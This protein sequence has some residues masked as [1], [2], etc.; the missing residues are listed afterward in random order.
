M[1]TQVSFDMVAM[2]V[3]YVATHISE[4]M[5]VFSYIGL[6][7]TTQVSFDIFVARG[8]N[9]RVRYD[10]GGLRLVGSLKTWVS[11]DKEPYKRDYVLQKRH[12]LLRSL[13]IIATS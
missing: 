6:F 12:V 3:R 2:R 10:M 8:S 11:F 1:T 9:S 7:L 13:R 5:I 4:K